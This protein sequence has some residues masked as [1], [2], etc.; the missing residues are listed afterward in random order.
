MVDKVELD[1]IVRRLDTAEQNMRYYSGQ[2][3]KEYLGG[4]NEDY[5]WG[6]VD[7]CAE[8][9]TRMTE[10]ADEIEIILETIKDSM[11]R[12]DSENRMPEVGQL[13]LPF[14]EF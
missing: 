7:G 4:I 3:V 9:A 10:M 12:S 8:G 6:Y 14:T 2:L 1:E 5:E 13:P 11:V